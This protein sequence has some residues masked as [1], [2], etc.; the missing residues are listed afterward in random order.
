M[1]LPV[2]GIASLVD[3]I[4][5]LRDMQNIANNYSQEEDDYRMDKIRQSA[6]DNADVFENNVRDMNYGTI[7]PNSQYFNGPQPEYSQSYENDAYDLGNS[8][9]DFLSP[10]PPVYDDPNSDDSDLQNGPFGGSNLPVYDDPDSDD[11]DLQNGPFGGSNLPV[12]D[13]PNSDDSDLQNGPFGGGGVFMPQNGGFMPQGNSFESGGG[14]SYFDEMGQATM[15]M[16]RGGR[17]KHPLD[18]IENIRRYLRGGFTGY[19]R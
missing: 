14:K 19:R 12:Y 3:Y 7:D 6:N 4:Q 13:D 1:A 2:L 15:A 8:L 9:S 10:N 11:S 18:S 5:Q 16:K 17:V